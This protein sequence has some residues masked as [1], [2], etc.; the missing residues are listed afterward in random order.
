MDA[1][2]AHRSRPA[3]QTQNGPGTSPF[4]ARQIVVL[5][6]GGHRVTNCSAA[7]VK[8]SLSGL[9]ARCIEAVKLSEKRVS[10]VT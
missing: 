6:T 1:A 7:A 10:S 9:A 3:A 4:R 2:E 5:E 8:R